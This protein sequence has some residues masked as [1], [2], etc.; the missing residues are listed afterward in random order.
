MEKKK[1]SAKKR[2]IKGRDYR[3][4]KNTDGK[5][6]AKHVGYRFS[7]DVKRRPTAAE[8]QSFHD[9]KRSDIYYEN[10]L[11]RSDR[12]PH[13]KRGERFKVG[14]RI[15]RKLKQTKKGVEQDKN[16]KALKSGVRISR[17]GGKNQFG[18]TKGGKKYTENRPNRSDENRTKKLVK[19]G[20]I[21]RKL[22]Q[23]KA[24]VVQDKNIK[25]L[26]SGRRV[27]R[28][29]GKNQ[30][31]KT[32]GNKVYYEA[33]VNRSDANRTKKFCS[34]GDMDV[35]VNRKQDETF[36][37]GG[38]IQSWTTK[39]LAE[40]LNMSMSDVNK[41][42]L[43]REDL[44]A[45]VESGLYKKGGKVD[46]TQK[47]FDDIRDYILDRIV[48]NSVEVV[49]EKPFVEME[50]IAHKEASK[51]NF[52]KFCKL[53]NTIS[54][55]WIKEP[56]VEM[57]QAIKDG[58][59]KNLFKFTY[60]GKAGDISKV[61]EVSD[62]FDIYIQAYHYE[63]YKKGGKIKDKWIADA[64][65]GHKGALRKTA[66][67]KGLL[68]DKND[69]LS[70]TD[71]HKLEKVG[72][73]TA[74]RAHLAETLGEFKDGGGVGKSVYIMHDEES[75][76]T[77]PF[78]QLRTISEIEKKAK[79]LGYT[80]SKTKNNDWIAVAKTESGD[81]IFI[82]QTQNPSNKPDI[83]KEGGK[84]EKEF[85]K[86]VKDVHSKIDEVVLKDGTH[87]DGKDLMTKGGK[88]DAELEKWVAMDEIYK[89]KNSAEK[90]WYEKT[91]DKL[92]NKYNLSDEGDGGVFGAE[93]AD[94][95]AKQKPKKTFE[96]GG[97]MGKELSALDIESKLGRKL[98]WSDY[99]TVSVGGKTYR[100][101]FMHGI[102][103]LEN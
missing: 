46:G 8:I 100:K 101:V 59:F 5:R 73:K 22:K 58:R 72:G 20:R 47:E 57:C 45:L 7:G 90:E 91:L 6:S 13:A 86:E 1:K 65:S 25:A 60:G 42:N 43:S 3:S 41:E 95:L 61:S 53:A 16:I 9:G 64:L 98:G 97:E 17:N 77:E 24:G 78:K 40:K 96:E 54:N 89:F 94:I 4:N 36:A 87:I 2:V 50:S 99:P 44:V 66:M 76:D 18:K 11:E 48:E 32:K 27:S 38:N 30:F 26:K 103:K 82:A 23:T 15:N 69:K 29:G 67:R 14:G 39:E 12:K 84:V 37:K 70:K 33:R 81:D 31:G 83:K 62:L 63:N 56:I 21:N 75:K 88:V 71:L 10:R 80:V 55:K 102:Y 19:G 34:G 74:K 49:D 28:K 35:R 92:I 93:L 68:K 79:E 51:E 52:E 85:V